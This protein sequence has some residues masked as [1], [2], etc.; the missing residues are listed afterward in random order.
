LFFRERLFLGQKRGP[1]P[2][3]TF[4]IFENRKRDV[5]NLNQPRGMSAKMAA[6]WFE[7]MPALTKDALWHRGRGNPPTQDG[8]FILFYRTLISGTKKRSKSGEDHFF[9]ER[10]FLG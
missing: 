7:P 4:F 9:R 8:F 1:K 5:I 10:L 3:K 6:N 2:A